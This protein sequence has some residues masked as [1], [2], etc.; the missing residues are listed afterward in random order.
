M[1]RTSPAQ[2]HGPRQAQGCAVR[3]LGPLL[4]GLCCVTATQAHQGAHVHGRIQLG[5]ALDGQQLVI[6]IDTPLDSLLGFEHAPSTAPQKKLAAEWAERLRTTGSLVRLPA[7]ARCTLLGA[8]LNA[9]VMGLGK[10]SADKAPHA[11]D[12]Q[13]GHADLEGQWSYRCEQPDALRTIDL[14]FFD[15]SPHART[16]DVQWAKDG[17]QGKQTLRRPAETELRKCQQV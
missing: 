9:P 3:L 1:K 12:H 7:Q 10:T 16:I 15:A 2:H 8:E 6:D 4:L 5:V 14:G 17:R 13:H 11:H